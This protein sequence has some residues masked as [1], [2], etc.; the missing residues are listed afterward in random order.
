MTSVK[1]QIVEARVMVAFASIG[2]VMFIVSTGGLLLL[3][4]GGVYLQDAPALPYQEF[5][6]TV[7]SWADW[8][9][10]HADTDV[11]IGKEK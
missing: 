6:F 7:T 10:T 4:P 1:R 11:Y 8:K 5:P 9:K 2:V 3:A